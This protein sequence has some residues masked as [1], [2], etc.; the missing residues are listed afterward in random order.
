[1]YDIEMFSAKFGPAFHVVCSLFIES[2]NSWENGFTAKV[3]AS[4]AQITTNGNKV[5]IVRIV[6]RSAGTKT[7]KLVRRKCVRYR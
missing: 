6:E 4:V 5:F 2:M 1:M 3:V 7:Y